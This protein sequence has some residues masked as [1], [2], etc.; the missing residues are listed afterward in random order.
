V[1][2]DDS[3]EDAV[4]IKVVIAVCFVVVLVVASV[5]SGGNSIGSNDSSGFVF[6]VL[7]GWLNLFAPVVVTVA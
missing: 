4:C 5:L 3:C 2:I 6:L 1:V 7:G